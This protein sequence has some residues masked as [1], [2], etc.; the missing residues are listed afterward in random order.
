MTAY[1]A[2]PSELLKELGTSAELGL[3]S[4]TVQQKLATHGENKLKEKAKKTTLQ[5]FADQFKDAM[6]LILIAAAAVSFAISETFKLLTLRAVASI[7]EIF[8]VIMCPFS[9][10]T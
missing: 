1:N 10:P 4:G 8:I 6:I 3:D 7:L 9:E 5:R 2:E